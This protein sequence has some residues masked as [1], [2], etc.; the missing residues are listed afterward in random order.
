M[1]DAG[2]QGADPGLGTNASRTIEVAHPIPPLTT[3][4][5]VRRL[6]DQACEEVLA[7]VT[8]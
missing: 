4:D 6:A 3:R 8:A 7:R 1:S 5:E 2:A